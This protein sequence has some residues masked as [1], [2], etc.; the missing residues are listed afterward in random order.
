MVFT[1]DSNIPLQKNYN[2]TNAETT[3]IVR[4]DETERFE[5]TYPLNAN[6]KVAVS[7]VNG[8][9]T[10]DTWDRSEVK[11]EAVKTADSKDRLSEVEI[12]IDA[13]QDAITI[14]TDYDSWKRDSNRGWR[15]Y[16]K[17]NVDYRLTVPRNAVLNQIETVNGSV[18]I[19]NSN[20][21]TKASTVN[22]QVNASNLRG[23]ASLSTVNGTVEANFDQLQAGSRIS[24]NTVN[25]QVNLTIPSDANATVKADTVNGSI[26]NDFGLPVRKGQYVGRDLYGRIGSGDVQIKLNSVNGGL[27]I[28]RKNDGKNV[29]PATNLLP[30]KGSDDADWEDDAFN[31]NKVNKEVAKA[32]KDVQKSMN[33]ARKEMQKIRP[34]LEKLQPEIDRITEESVREVN[35]ALKESVKVLSSEEIKQRLKDV[36]M[37]QKE[38]LSR[39]SVVNFFPGAPIIEK[40]NAAFGVK[41]IAKV[42]IDAKD[43]DVSV[44]G[45]DKSEVRYSVTRIAKNRSQKPIDLKVEHTDSTVNLKIVNNPATTGNSIVD[46]S[47]VR[48]EVYVPKKSNLRILTDR[49]IRLENVSG[50]IELT[51]VDESINV[52]D[53]SGKLTVASADGKIRVIGFK[54]EIQSKTVDGE[55]SLEGDFLKFFAQ[56]QDG[57][58]ILT[59]PENANVN[60]ESNTKEVQAE[61]FPFTFVSENKNN[62]IFKIGKGGEKFRF[63]VG[64]GQIYIR[65]AGNLKT[66]Y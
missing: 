22:G 46:L 31:S 39:A 56:S 3:K 5:Q 59:L 38:A 24:L 21:L 15:N 64:E 58:I 7:N 36:Q 44:K 53:A 51:G 66:D 2:Y 35:E 28:K 8:S 29:N 43:C 17:L 49:E 9:I 23:T 55:M 61:G 54:G 10:I 16:G 62:S 14:E 41:G 13:R 42:T 30:A 57:T 33:D 32:Q 18:T 37:R 12:K 6:G 40:K 19:T 11:L 1:S 60:I 63:A 25:G 34:E 52:R 48:V 50:E 4:L 20:N 65:S 26:N 47:G 27:N 45:W